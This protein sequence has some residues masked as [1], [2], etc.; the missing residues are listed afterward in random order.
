MAKPGLHRA[1]VR[2]PPRARRHERATTASGA[3]LLLVIGVLAT[4][5]HHSLSGGPSPAVA[6]TQSSLS[7]PARTHLRAW[8]TRAEPSLDALLAARHQIASAAANND[9]PATVLTCEHAAGAV[10]GVDR[11][12]PSPD[13][14]LTIA[15]QRAIGNYRLALDHCIGGA[16]NQDAGD[17]LQAATYLRQASEEMQAAVDLLKRDLPDFGSRGDTVIT[18]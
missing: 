6:A 11:S 2:R 12:L 8:L 1:A 17:F 18:V 10:S 4:W 3:V 13:S 14:A 9:V 5:A 16:H 7:A 15:L